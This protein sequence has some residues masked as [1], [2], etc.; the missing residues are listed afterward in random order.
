VQTPPPAVEEESGGLLLPLVAGGIAL[1]AAVGGFL[2]FRRRKSASKESAGTEGLTQSSRSVLEDLTGPVSEVADS[3]SVFQ[4][5]AG[6]SVNTSQ[7]ALPPLSSFSMDAPGAF[8]MS[9]VDPVKE[10]DLY[11]DYNKDAQAEEILLDALQKGSDRLDIPLKLLEIY[12]LR[13]SEKQF[14]ALA[15]ELQARTGG[16]GEEWEKVVSLGRELD[17]TNPLYGGTGAAQPVPDAGAATQGTPEFSID[18]P[19]SLPEPNFDFGTET[20]PM[21][22]PAAAHDDA[23]SFDFGGSAG[24][25]ETQPVARSAPF[26]APE[27]AP[28]TDF[29]FGFAATPVK[30]EVKP[31]APEVPRAPAPPPVAPAKVESFFATR[32][33]EPEPVSFAPP[34]AEEKITESKLG[35]SEILG[36]APGSEGGLQEPDDDLEFDASLTESTVLGEADFTS[37]FFSSAEAVSIDDQ[38]T[39]LPDHDDVEIDADLTKSTILGGAMFSGIDLELGGGET[40]PAPAAPPTAKAPPAPALDLAA[41]LDVGRA[42]APPAA[43]APSDSRRDEVNTKLELAQAYED[44]GDLEGARE[45]LNEVLGEGAPDQI[46]Q[47]QGILSRLS[48]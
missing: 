22:A 28:T 9:E 8:D 37:S 14:N 7:T 42:S 36:L 38:T 10:A 12:A 48:A 2:F 31:V 6:Q 47:A 46:A 23:F 19:Q 32:T 27:A 18:A 5:P 43:A 44:M 3:N 16:Q 17:P 26:E 34:K 15:S 39:A 1:V 24:A 45:L 13:K 25:T 41:E 40:K 33:P 35:V 29:D 30:E 4:T 21:N 11:L 20:D